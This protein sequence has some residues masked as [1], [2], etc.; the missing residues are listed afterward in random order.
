MNTK[1][2]F[3]CVSKQAQELSLLAEKIK[4]SDTWNMEDLETLCIMAGMTNEWNNS[5]GETFESVI[6]DAAEKLGVRII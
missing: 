2:S 3:T 6:F 4:C 5:D 1:E